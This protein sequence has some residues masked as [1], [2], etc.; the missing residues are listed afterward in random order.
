MNYEEL[1][2]SENCQPSSS[3]NPDDSTNILVKEDLFQR[4]F[5]EG[6]DLYDPVQYESSISEFFPE[7]PALTPVDVSVATNA[8][9]LNS[10]ISSRS[11]YSCSLQAP[12]TSSFSSSSNCPSSSGE[13]GF[14]STLTQETTSGSSVSPVLSSPNM[15]TP[16]MEVVSSG[17]IS[18]PS[19]KRSPWSSIT[20]LLP[21]STPKSSGRFNSPLRNYLDP[22]AAA[23]AKEAK[24]GKATSLECIEVLEAKKKKENEAAEK[25]ERK[26][27][28]ERKKVE[29]E[30]LA[31]KKKEP[32]LEQKK[33]REA[34]L[35][36]A[37]AKKVTVAA[38]EYHTRSAAS[39][40]STVFTTSSESSSVTPTPTLSISLVSPHLSL[41]VL[42]ILIYL[43]QAHYTTHI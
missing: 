28:R 42:L 26:K 1:S 2:D 23:T 19:M 31:R 37:A 16:R 22:I 12:L 11:C 6:Y 29:R 20:N 5:E 17:G 38:K 33:K 32:R 43:H 15:S 14:S 13:N 36:E 4:R 18:S 21:G 41:V 39:T 35:K 3:A 10:S 27:E 9:N 7:T 25:E 40:C 30:E 24:T 8:H 34:A